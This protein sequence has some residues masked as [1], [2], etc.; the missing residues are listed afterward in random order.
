MAHSESRKRLIRHRE[1]AAAVLSSCRRKSWAA[2]LAP[3]TADTAFANEEIYVV[4][5]VRQ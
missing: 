5:G 3:F 4:S 1:H 2:L